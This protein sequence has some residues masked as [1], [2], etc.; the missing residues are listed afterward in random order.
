MVA[1]SDICKGIM[2]QLYVLPNSCNKFKSFGCGVIEVD[3]HDL[4]Q[5]DRAMKWKSKE[6]PLIIIANTIK[7]KGISDIEN[8]MF[9][10]HHR[11]PSEEEY[12]KFIKEIDEK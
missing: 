6:K 8:N 1:S 4:K 10:W 12:K 2:F 9:A 7:G 3:G 11:A 5:L